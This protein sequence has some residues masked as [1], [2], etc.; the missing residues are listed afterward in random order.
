MRHHG[1]HGYRS[2]PLRRN[3]SPAERLPPKPLSGAESSANLQKAAAPVDGSDERGATPAPPRGWHGMTARRQTRYL[4][5]DWK[6]WGAL[7]A[8]EFVIVDVADYSPAWSAGLRSGSWII[9]IDGKSFE[10]FEQFGAAVGAALVAK[11]FHSVRGA[12]DAVVTLAARPKVKRAPRAASRARVPQVESGRTI[13]RY[14]RPKW[15]APN[16]RKLHIFRSRPA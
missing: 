9:E 3:P 14:D 5:E 15:C 7:G 4:P 16:W 12:V 8:G 10:D 2:R 11:A 1:R 6:V 13:T